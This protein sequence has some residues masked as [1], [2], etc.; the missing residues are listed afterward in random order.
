MKLL[1]TAN[2][3]KLNNST[4]YA[5]TSHNEVHQVKTSCLESTIFRKITHPIIL[6]YH[7]GPIR[8]VVHLQQYTMK[9][10]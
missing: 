4:T 8:R 3:Y 5:A 2:G 7:D 6:C 10:P 1:T 9:A